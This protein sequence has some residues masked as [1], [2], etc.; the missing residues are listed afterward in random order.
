MRDEVNK[1]NRE[2]YKQNREDRVA[3]AAKYLAENRDE[4]N[5]RARLRY[6]EDLE[7]QG[8]KRAK[9]KELNSKQRKAWRER[10]KAHIQTYVKAYQRKYKARRRRIRRESGKG[11]AEAALRRAAVLNA[12]PAWADIKAI[13]AIYKESKRITRTTGI[14][15]HVDHIIPLVSDV[16]CGLHVAE[17]LQIVTAAHNL[18][19]SNK[20]NDYK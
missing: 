10:N 11:N 1:R 20:F 8:E 12:T 14:Q 19:K 5:Q 15:Y 6:H 13:E 17:N 18:K 16:V 3:Y 7:K 4:V 2:Y 9:N